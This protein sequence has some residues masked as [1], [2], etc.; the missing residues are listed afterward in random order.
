MQWFAFNHSQK[1]YG[2]R[3][4]EGSGQSALLDFFRDIGA[5]TSMQRDN[6]KMQTSDLWEKY[7][8]QR[9]VGNEF[10]EPYHSSQN[11]AECQLAIH[12]QR[13]KGKMITTGCDPRAWFKNIIKTCNKPQ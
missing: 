7:L 2:M 11:P 4:S 8:R 9:N 5:P 13:M 3:T 1:E 10:T 6:S 12:K